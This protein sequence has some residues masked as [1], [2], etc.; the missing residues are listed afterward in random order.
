M[1]RRQ[2]IKQTSIATVGIIISSSL[3]SCSSEALKLS[4][5]IG[6]PKQNLSN[7]IKE[8]D[9]FF[10]YY[11]LES[12]DFEHDFVDGDKAFLFASSNKIVGFTIKIEGVSDVENYIEKL[13]SLYNEKIKV[14]DNIF[15]TE[16]LWKAKNKH[17]KLCYTKPYEGLEQN[18]HYSE[19]DVNSNLIV[20]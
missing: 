20:F 3:V 19:Y 18:M 15:G 5:L 1:D 6:K 2:F 13:N 17:I 4:T 11:T 7:F 10:S 12:S 16:Y 8:G 14:I 9:D